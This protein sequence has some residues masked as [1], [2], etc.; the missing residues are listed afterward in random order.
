MKFGIKKYWP[1]LVIFGVLLLAFYPVWTKGQI[2]LNG[3]N[4]PGFFSPWL[5]TQ[6]PGFPAGVPSKPGMLDQLRLYYPYLKLTQDTYRLGQLPLWNP[7]QFAGNPHMA[8]WQSGIFYP[9]HLLLPLLPLPVYWTLFQALGF[10]LSGLFTYLFLKHLKLHP[11]PSLFGSLSFMLSTFM[12]TWAQEVIVAPHSILWLPLILLSVDKFLSSRSKTWWFVGL[13]AITASILSGYWQTTF[14]LLVTVLA[15]ILWRR[16]WPLLAWFPLSLSLTAFQLL[17][18]L[19][20]YQLSSRASINTSP[21]LLSLFKDFL[22]K[23]PH[24]LTLLIP[25]FFGHPTT[26]NWFGYATGNYYE[27]AL[28]IGTLPIFFALLA[29]LSKAKSKALIWFFALL[30][31]IGGSF[32]FN[33]PHS[34]FIFDAKLPLLSTNIANRI[35][36]LPAF[37]LSVLSAFGFHLWINSKKHLSVWLSTGLITLSFI[38]IWAFLLTQSSGWA[39]ISLRNSVLPTAVWLVSLG[40]IITAIFSPKLRLLA[41]VGLLI[42][43]TG[44]NLYQHFKFTAFSPSRFV[45]PAHPAID[46]LRTHAGLNRFMG[47]HTTF[48]KPNLATYYGLYSAEGFDSLNDT[49]RSQLIFSSATGQL[50]A[51]LPRSADAILDQDFTNPRT[52]R[53]MSLL[54]IKYLVAYPQDPEVGDTTRLSQLPPNQQKLVW[55]DHGWSIYEYTTALPRAFLASSFIKATDRQKTVDLIYDPRINL[56]E[57]VILDTDVSL[58][59]A[60][61]PNEQVAITQYTPTQITL[62]TKSHTNQLLFLSDTYYPGWRAKVDGQ[63]AALLRADLAF[64]AVPVPAGNHTVTMTFFPDSFKLGL[65]IASISLFLTLCL[66]KI[67]P[68]SA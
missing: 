59:L 12:F 41:A 30:T 56:R 48:L 1:I 45:Y 43:A 14:Y 53:L 65:I 46:F 50:T 64:R 55:Q 33:L 62:T 47:Y 68:K 17:P 38:I 20:L 67:W 21:Q 35:L 3:P 39:S 42:L 16:A 2:P 49:L 51:N 25:D 40:I 54:G 15:Y 5:Y 66:L 6:F 19:E 11:L 57:Q 23:S 24:L 22:L 29:I 9:L 26:R 60:D 61:D 8:E 31:L 36:F 7:H 44:Q 10:F 32:A 13:L 28:F 52:L 34:R 37:G 63:P 18:T 58:D 27:A 4:L